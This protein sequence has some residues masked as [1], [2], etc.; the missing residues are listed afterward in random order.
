VKRNDGNVLNELLRTAAGKIAQSCAEKTRDLK[1]AA[2][3]GKVEV[4]ITCA[5]RDLTGAEISLPDIR[6]GEDNKV[7]KGDKALPVEASASV[8]VDGIVVGTTPAKVKLA[9]GLHKLRLM[10]A[11]CDDY[12]AA[13][14]AQ[15]G[16]QLAPTLQLTEAGYAR[17]KDMRAFLSGL[18]NGRKLTDAEVKVLEG[19]AQMFRQSGILIKQ[20]TKEDIKVDTKDGLKVYKS[21]Y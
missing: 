10:R 14:D 9:P 2:P 3:A 7:I 4:A 18:D 13:I 11:G 17:W 5:L 20:D 16:L 12:Q 15:A 1:V 21:L 8:E 6:L 19:K